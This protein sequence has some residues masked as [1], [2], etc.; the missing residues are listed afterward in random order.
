MFI[1]IDSPIGMSGYSKAVRE[2]FYSLNQ[3]GKESYM[4]VPEN[5][6]FMYVPEKIHRHIIRTMPKLSEKDVLFFRPYFSPIPSVKAK[7]IANVV[8]ESTRLPER[9]VRE[10]N[11]NRVNQVWVPSK[12]CYD[13]AENC[14]IIEDKLRIVPHGYDPEIFSYKP[15]KHD[16]FVFL[17]VGGYVGRGDRKGADL[18][19]EAWNSWKD[20]PQDVVCHMKIN[21][22]YSVSGWKPENWSR[23]LGGDGIIVNPMNYI[24]KEMANIYNVADC[25]VNPSYGEGFNMSLLEAMACGL[26]VISSLFGGQKDYLNEVIHND[27]RFFALM[28]ETIP[29]KFSPWDCG[30]WEKPDFECLVNSLKWAYEDKPKKKPYSHLKEWTWK[31]SV[32][33][34][35]KCLEEL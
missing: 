6:P 29:A 20:R 23:D 28:T 18:L 17:F 8:L 24:D 30:S 14:G 25:F 13:I 15:I 7:L 1:S 2:L 5:A 26:P 16:N 11:D 27:P 12:H 9:L 4:F 3:I 35:K 31:K 32:I 22:T 19:V 10:C 34:A 21:T 33:I